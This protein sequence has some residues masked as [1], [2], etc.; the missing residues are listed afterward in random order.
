MAIQSHYSQVTTNPQIYNQLGTQ[1]NRFT[2]R[3]EG[4][5]AKRQIAVTATFYSLGA[6]RAFLS[7]R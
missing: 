1:R 3:L 4:P 5:R 2:V 6:I 7:S